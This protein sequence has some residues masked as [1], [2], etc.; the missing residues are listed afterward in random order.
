MRPLEFLH[1]CD[2]ATEFPLGAQP[3]VA[4]PRVAQA[5]MPVPSASTENAETQK[6]RTAVRPYCVPLP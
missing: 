6:E 2:M 4:V 1:F 3:G 5:L